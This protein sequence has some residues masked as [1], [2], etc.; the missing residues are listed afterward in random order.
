MPD[1][2]KHRF[3][4]LDE[5]YVSATA[6]RLGIMNLPS[7]RSQRCLHTLIDRLL[8]PIRL[9]FRAPIRITSGYRCPQLN[10]A[11]G[12]S[13][14][15]DHM[16]GCA[17][18]IQPLRYDRFECRRLFFLIRDMM[19]DESFPVKQLINE[20]DFTW[21]HISIDIDDLQ[22]QHVSITPRHQVL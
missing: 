5:F 12:G 17:A 1:N 13:L 9:K 11:V 3:F 18:D 2:T 22:T 4:R 6:T 16:T 19:Q 15:S 21:I 14:S 10:A 8:D 20:Q 7:S